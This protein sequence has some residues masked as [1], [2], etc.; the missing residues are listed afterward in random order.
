[1]PTLRVHR[2][3]GLAALLAAGALVLAAC[4][5][6]QDDPARV[7]WS[8][9]TPSATPSVSGSSVSG[10]SVPDDGPLDR[11]QAC[12]AM[13]VSGQTP[14]EKRV[15]EALVDAT[16]GFDTSVAAEM[17]DLARDLGRLRDRVPDEFVRPLEQVRV[18]FLQMQE[19][20]DSGA[21]QTVELDVATA[22]EGLKAYRALC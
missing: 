9:A 3:G 19:H 8:S 16:E 18:P 1:M 21:G 4:S 5:G 2:A 17:N 10:S 11:D 15:G 13:Y 22:V 7:S 12:A 14:L 6:Q 20:I